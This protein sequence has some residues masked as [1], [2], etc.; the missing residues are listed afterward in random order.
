VAVSET[1]AE[2]GKWAEENK[3]CNRG[4]VA[5]SLQSKIEEVSKWK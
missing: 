1:R 2:A 3:I 5:H 4:Y